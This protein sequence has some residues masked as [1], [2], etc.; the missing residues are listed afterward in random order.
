MAGR[1]NWNIGMMEYWN[2]GRTSPEN[3]RERK[4]KG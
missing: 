4:K 2:N 3:V 1:H